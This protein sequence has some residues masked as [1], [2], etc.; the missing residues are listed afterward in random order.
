MIDK[1][2]AF[3]DDLPTLP[4]DGRDHEFDRFLAHFLGDP[5]RPGIQERFRIGGFGGCT[6]PPGDNRIEIGQIEVAHCS[7]FWSGRHATASAAQ[8]SSRMAKPRSA[9]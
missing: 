4:F 2:G 1:V 6:G 9:I 8:P 7:A 3:E 5:A